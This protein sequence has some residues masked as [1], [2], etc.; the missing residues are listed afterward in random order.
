MGRGGSQRIMETL[1]ASLYAAR[2]A[3]TG[4]AFALGV[5][6][7]LIEKTTPLYWVAQLL[8]IPLA[9]LL[10]GYIFYKYDFPKYL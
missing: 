10:V 7:L 4:W 6:L 5:S 2:H 9:L 8:I 3:Y 1:K